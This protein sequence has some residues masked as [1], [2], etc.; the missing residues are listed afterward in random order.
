MKTNRVKTLLLASIILTVISGALTFYN[1]MEKRRATAWV[2][3]TYEI[4]Q[5]STEILSLLQDAE[6]GQRG[7]LITGDSLYLESITLADEGLPVKISRLTELTTNHDEQHASIE[8]LKP[9]ISTRMA[10]I[11]QT[12]AAYAQ[13]GRDSADALARKNASYIYMGTLR[14]LL[15]AITEHEKDLLAQRNNELD[16]IYLINDS[17][18]YSSFIFTS[19]ISIIALLIIIQGE[20][21]NNQLITKLETLNL[22]LEGKVRERTYELAKKNRLTEELNQSLQDSLEEVQLFYEALQIKSAK[23]EDTLKEIRD[24][25]DL[26]PCGYHSLDNEGR[27]VRMN[28]T[29]LNWLGYTRDEVVGKLR[30]PD[31]L[32]DQGKIE[33]KKKFLQ[34]KKQGY[35]NNVEFDLVRKDGTL[36]PIFLNATAV[37]DAGGAFK[38]TRTTVFDVTQRKEIEKALLESNEKLVA[39]NIEKNHILS[40]A[41]HDL[42]SPLNGIIGLLN[43]IKLEKGDSGQGE[44][45]EAQ[46]EYIRYIEQAC[47]NMQGLI[48]NL[49]DINRIEAGKNLIFP[50]SVALHELLQRHMQAFKERARKKDITLTLEHGTPGAKIHTDQNA[51][52]RIL[53]NLLSNAI[54]FSPS[55]K[56]VLLRVIHNH[57]I[58]RFEVI[59]EGPGIRAEDMPRLFGKFQRLTAKPTG[60]ESSTGLGLSIVK[61]LV[62]A[63]RGRISVESE[64]N[65]GAKFIVELPVKI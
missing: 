60:G 58:V 63:L 32:T 4:I 13:H 49:L 41:A 27:V 18:I 8:Q 23:S 50:Q 10:I 55:G 3:H 29:E 5:E 30:F 56:E 2:A 20:T 33:F 9:L 46:R 16:R 52:T 1:T 11:Q 19:V 35:I 42:K 38:M 14:K 25:Y 65:K 47:T 21:R 51:L 45:S 15:D 17:V 36:L 22:T 43:L 28:Q 40:I 57:A 59:D 62:I 44:L 54:K 24:L 53:E 7:Y 26:A 64:A 34:F 37:Y 6:A 12:L 48:T 61:E 31:L 39:L